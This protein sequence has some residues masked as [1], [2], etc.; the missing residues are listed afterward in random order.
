MKINTEPKERTTQEKVLYLRR[1]L[2]NEEICAFVGC[3]MEALKKYSAGSS[4]NP[5]PIF[6]RKMDELVARFDK[7]DGK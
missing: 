3:S 1:E 2:T 7:L 5:L 6:K 4:K